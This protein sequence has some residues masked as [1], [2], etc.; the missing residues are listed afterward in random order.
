MSP[1]AIGRNHVLELVQVP[2]RF[3]HR[4]ALSK[5][6]FPTDL[7]RA[8]RWTTGEEGYTSEEYYWN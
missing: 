3:E 7:L 8:C 5:P 6:L 2:Y 1:E 4:H